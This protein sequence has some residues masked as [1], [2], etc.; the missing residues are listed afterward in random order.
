MITEGLQGRGLRLKHHGM[1]G[2]K[3]G[4]ARCQLAQSSNQN[5]HRLL[6]VLTGQQVVLQLG[7]ER[8]DCKPESQ[9]VLCE[10]PS[11]GSQVLI[12]WLTLGGRKLYLLLLAELHK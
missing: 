7:T 12:S 4:R 11:N 5:R 3:I 9:S 10:D 8:H 1:E 2:S 6:G